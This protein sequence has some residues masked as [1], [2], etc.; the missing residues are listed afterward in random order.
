M[1]SF[2]CGE[3]IRIILDNASYYEDKTDY[4]RA[5]RFYEEALR[6]DPH[7]DKA[8]KSIERINGILDNYIFKECNCNVGLMPGVLQ[9][10]RDSV[11][12]V[13]QRSRTIKYSLEDIHDVKVSMGSLNFKVKDSPGSSTFS[14]RNAKEWVELITDAQN[15]IFPNTSTKVQIGYAMK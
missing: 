11:V 13:N 3:D 14:L 10:K 7:N 9:L 15:N 2:S 4:D 8:K 5:M 6:I 12:F 1:S